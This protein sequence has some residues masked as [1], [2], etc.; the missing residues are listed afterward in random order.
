M[1]PSHLLAALLTACLFSPVAA[2][3][4]TGDNGQSVVE[5]AVEPQVEGFALSDVRL[6][7]SPFLQAMKKDAEYLFSLDPDRLLHGFFTESG[8]E[9]KAEGYAGW[10][11]DGLGGHTL[12]HY[13]SATSMYFAAS[14]DSEILPRIDHIV[15]EMASIQRHR[16]DGYVA[17]IP[18]GDSL[19]TKVHNRDI[20][21][22]GFRLNGVWAP[23]YTMHKQLAGLLDAYWNAGNDRALIVARGLA[24]WA[25]ETTSTLDEA[26]WQ[27]MLACEYGG[28]NEALAN[29]YGVTGDERYLE[30]S[31][32]FHDTNVLHPLAEGIPD[33]TGLH[34]N[35]QIPKVIG[36]ARQYELIGDD[37]LKTIA[38]FFWEQMVDDHSYV[39]G[40]NSMG[41]FLAEPDV[42]AD[43]LDATTAETCN[44]YNMLRLT[45]HLFTL[46]PKARY[47]DY[48]ERA[49]YNHILASQDPDTGMFTYYMSLKPGH[50]KTYSTAEG[51]FWCCVGSGMEN[52]VRYGE[53]I[54]FHS[55]RD[56]WVNLFI[57]S[58]L[59]WTDQGVMLTQET[60]FPASGAVRFT[61]SAD[62]PKPL[63]LHLRIP[64]WVEGNVDVAVNGEPV[65]YPSAS[66][67][68]LELARTWSDGDV[69][70][71]TLPM[72]LRLESMPDNADRV[73]IMY[74]PV[75]LGGALGTK[76][77]PEGGAFAD[78]DVEFIEEPVPDVPVLVAERTRLEDWIQ[79]LAG[80][81]LTFHTVGAGR[82][83]D[84]VLKP[85]YRI[86][87]ERYSIYWDLFDE[88]GWAREKADYEAA[89]AEQRAIDENTVENVRLGIMLVEQDHDFEGE[90]SEAGV[91]FGDKYR[92]ASPGGW[93]AFDI[94]VDPDASNDLMCTYWGGDRG[95]RRFSISVEGTSV[96]EQEL[97]FDAPGEFFTVRYPLPGE[98]TSRRS[99]VRLRFDSIERGR[100][101]RVFDCR[102]LRR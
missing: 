58:E 67:T 29:L 14:G 20:Q 80:D 99:S 26:D 9:P 96:A 38:D 71:M 72:A 92:E 98:L 77:M 5:N 54:Y 18:G 3:P 32:K 12:G 44:T 87:H 41:E 43:R 68:Y 42:L 90:H 100:V 31:R 22:S 94:A 97:D 101:G 50:Y 79:P 62:A 51:A 89:R 46:E 27:N 40:G 45:R 28:M 66:G 73:A 84:V 75:V 13:L 74:G 56:L 34:A 1:R 64:A 2:Q 30:L 49:L 48:Y 33:L 52:H 37:S 63:S 78:S 6:L 81:P 53:A 55:D 4:W 36:V 23:W 47:A 82:P 17:A 93:F 85:F 25:V 39:I 8:L 24:D 60:D 88:A 83:A 61:V 35:T 57:P 95:G 86:H 11:R 65:S 102:T 10:E 21:T 69:V 19:W 91:A 15:R 16:G 59:S 70:E 76:G 7:D